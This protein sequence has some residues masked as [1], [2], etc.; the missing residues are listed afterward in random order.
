MLSCLR[1]EFS[2]TTAEELI[3]ALSFSDDLRTRMLSVGT[4][5]EFDA[6]VSKAEA[7]LGPELV[8]TLRTVRQR[9]ATGAIRPP[10]DRSPS[11]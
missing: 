6:L 4:K 11:R 2:I 8:E 5:E 1:D 9:R 10:S 7:E 3:E